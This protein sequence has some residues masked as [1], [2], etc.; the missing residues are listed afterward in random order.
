MAHGTEDWQNAPEFKTFEQLLYEQSGYVAYAITT[1]SVFDVPYLTLNNPADS[2]VVGRVTYVSYRMSGAGIVNLGELS[3][4]GGALGYYDYNRYFGGPDP[5]C[6]I[7]GGDQPNFTAY[8]VRSAYAEVDKIG[9]FTNLSFIITPGHRISLM[10][11]LASAQL[12]GVFEWFE[13]PI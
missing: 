11:I 12:T 10:G 8:P 9:E 3:F 2:G 5:E 6:E 4:Q 1:A 13:V 7:R